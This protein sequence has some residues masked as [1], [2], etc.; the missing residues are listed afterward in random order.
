MIRQ[1]VKGIDRDGLFPFIVADNW[2]SPEEEKLI[3][4]ELD[5]YYRPEN[6][7]HASENSAADKG[8]KL[9]NSWRI[10]PC[11]MYNK[12]Y[13]KFS[14]IV[15]SVN[16]YLSPKFH[17][18]IRESMPQGVQFM[19]ATKMNTMISYYDNSQEYKNH[20]DT[21]QFTSIIWFYKEPKKF[22]GGDFVLTQSDQTIECKHNRMI[23]FPSYYMHSVTPVS[24][25]AEN[26]NKGLGRFA[27]TN[28]FVS[29]N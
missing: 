29:P 5:F 1:E 20:F 10:Y 24:I 6:L 15:S 28:F 14:T 4:K 25:D 8:E 3:W 7:Q 13:L 22:T 9:S 18:F 11:E 23:F 2:Y 27:I 21:V 26:R 16:K 12:E 19:N 17:N